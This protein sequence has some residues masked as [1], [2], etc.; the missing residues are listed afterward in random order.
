MNQFLHWLVESPWSR[1]QAEYEWLFAVIQSL[2][3]VGF[4]FLIG[5]IAVVDLR[6]IGAA[7]RKQS[8]GELATDLNL[9]KWAG[10]AIMLATGFMMFSSSA[11]AYRWNTSFRLKMVC[12]ATALLFHFTWRR[13]VLRLGADGVPAKIAGIT[14]LVLWTVVVAAGRM[15]AFV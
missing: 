4:A 2:H 10:L 8:P 13:R 14:S 1:A 9:C 3:F 7:M 11:T 15:I 12:L 5:T 6:L